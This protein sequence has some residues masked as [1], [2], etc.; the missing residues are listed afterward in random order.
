LI[1]DRRF[2]GAY[3]L[4]HQGWNVGRQSFYTAVHPRRQFWTSYSPPWELEISH[5]SYCVY[6]KLMT[7]STLPT[8]IHKQTIN[9][10]FWKELKRLLSLHYSTI[11]ISGIN[12][13]KLYI[14]VVM[15][16]SPAVK[17][18]SNNRTHR[19]TSTASTA[20][21]QWSGDRDYRT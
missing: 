10:K 1:V 13:S 4:H 8:F 15:V 19:C 11:N 5:S 16:T 20:T 2:R 12:Y 7:F 9:N 21:K 17:Q 14:L 3:C 18:W 6:K